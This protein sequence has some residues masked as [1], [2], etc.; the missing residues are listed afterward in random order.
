[1]LPVQTYI[2]IKTYKVK[3]RLATWLIG[4]NV[5]KR[6]S[7]S[8]DENVKYEKLNIPNEFFT[9]FK[10]NYNYKNWFENVNPSYRK[11]IYN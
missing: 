9:A 1:M 10:R 8:N 2:F 3:L 11:E 4:I 7:L 6:N 5:V